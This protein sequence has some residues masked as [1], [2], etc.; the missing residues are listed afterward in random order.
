[1]AAALPD[2]EKQATSLA[3]AS[4]ETTTTTTTTQ[5]AASQPLPPTGS[6]IISTLE[7]HA[8]GRPITT[9][10]DLVP[11]PASELDDED[12]DEDDDDD[13]HS[14]SHSS[15]HSHDDD[16]NNNNNNNNERGDGM[17]GGPISRHLTHTATHT[18]IT[19]AASRPPDFE[20]TFAPDD[21]EDPRNW[22][23]WYRAYTVLAVSY[24][25]W[26]VVLYSTS[27][28]AT[29]SQIMD[30]FDITSRPVATLGLTTYLLGLAA[31]SV[32]VAPLS[33]VYGRRVV[34]LVCLGV[35]TVL[36]V[37]CA[38]AKSLGVLIGVRFVGALFGS[39]LISNSPGTVVD[40]AGH[41]TLALCM[42]WYSIAPLNGPVTG[43][44][45]GG[46]VGEGLGWRWANWLA[47]ILSGVA[48]V[49]VALVKETYAPALLKRKAERLRKETG[50]ERWWCRHDQ[51]VS[52][53]A[54][55]RANLSRPFVLA[56]TEPILWFF[57]IWISIVY[58]ILY[59]CFVAY[60]IVFTLHRG[61]S[62]SQTGLSFLGIGV[63]TLLA[64]SLEPAWRRLIDRVGVRRRPD[65]LDPA[66][67]GPEATALV[68][69]IGAC[70]TAAGQLAF[71][72][73]CL[74]ASLSPLVPIAM[75]VP[76]GMGNTLCFVYGSHYLAGAYGAE[77]AASA[78][79]GNAVA[80]SVVG[81]ALPLAGTAMYDALTP[82]WAGTLLGG[83]EVVLISVPWAFYKY[84][85]RIRE[86]SPVIREMR[87]EAM[88]RERRRERAEAR[89]ARV[90]MRRLRGEGGGNAG[91]E[92]AAG[93]KKEEEVREL[94]AAQGAR[95][96]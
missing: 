87:E 40:I 96:A 37:P 50:E 61:W 10:Q 74:P 32:V 13:S 80:R 22:P 94:A 75:G 91:R 46:Y 18:S 49:M 83:M 60:P 51:R 92:E 73:T 15:H 2:L 69:T 26:V 76:F 28:T 64:I 71:S 72:W 62:V 95:M 44:L 14:H 84:G 23:L 11:E 16:D 7:E 54:L 35:F 58:G 24:A 79:A 39:A 5:A 86:R 52:T 27:Y 70:L 81:A 48:F 63:G 3:A 31:G 36:I 12:D 85:D 33:E 82:R 90:E 47:L 57:N 66:R 78:L 41:E 1:M 34:Y 30:E 38:L 67:A 20:V 8:Y 68:M 56:A 9:V 55:L 29:V 19:S 6:N 89:K 45:I 53:A 77:H 88:K 42:S 17:A 21:P 25:T 65:P 4:S 59:L 43:P 93:E